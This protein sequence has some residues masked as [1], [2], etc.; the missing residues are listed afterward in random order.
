M[1]LLDEE[2]TNHNL[3]LSS[4]AKPNVISKVNTTRINQMWTAM[5]D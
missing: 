1:P 5:Q 4:L 3:Y 2:S